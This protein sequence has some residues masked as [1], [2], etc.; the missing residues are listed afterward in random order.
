ML[1]LMLHSLQ[2]SHGAVNFILAQLYTGVYTVEHSGG[3]GTYEA[4]GARGCAGSKKYSRWRKQEGGKQREQKR[5]AALGDSLSH[6]EI[7]SRGVFCL[8]KALPS[9]ARWA[10]SVV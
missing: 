8:K 5:S 1:N 7:C 3:S 6:W 4:I 10:T 2:P 9:L